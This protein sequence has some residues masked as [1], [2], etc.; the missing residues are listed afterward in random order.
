MP[1]ARH[2]QT[3][4]RPEEKGGGREGLR[5]E[6][7]GGERKRE[8]GREGGPGSERKSPVREGL[9]GSVWEGGRRERER[10]SIGGWVKVSGGVYRGFNWC[11]AARQ[12]ALLLKAS[13]A[14]AAGLPDGM[15]TRPCL[16][17]HRYEHVPC[18]AGHDGDWRAEAEIGVWEEITRSFDCSELCLEWLLLVPSAGRS[19]MR[20]V[21]PKRVVQGREC[22]LVEP[23]EVGLGV[24]VLCWR[25]TLRCRLRFG[26]DHHW[27]SE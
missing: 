23:C 10:A 2:S 22:D 11:N 14:R 20:P 12:D 5:G 13:L 9:G 19:P 24:L 16:S 1:L 4:Q 26:A 3:S 8:A 15:R 17:Q 18:D 6:E 27:V 21:V 25:G 7:E